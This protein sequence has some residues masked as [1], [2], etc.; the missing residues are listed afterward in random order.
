MERNI[1][2]LSR[3]ITSNILCSHE[4]FLSYCMTKMKKPKKLQFK[5][6]TVFLWISSRF[7]ISSAPNRELQVFRCKNILTVCSEMPYQIHQGTKKLKTLI[8]PTKISNR[9]EFL[10]I[11]LTQK[12]QE[13][14]FFSNFHQ[15]RAYSPILSF[16][17]L[18]NLHI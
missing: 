12:F 7:Q 16:L 8:S 14:N 2:S 15:N 17:K 1:Q 13:K 3:G 11:E 18:S 4:L 10:H 5:R 9:N 6:T